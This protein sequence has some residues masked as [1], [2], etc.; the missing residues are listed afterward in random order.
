MS[1]FKHAKNYPIAANELFDLLITKA[2]C[3]RLWPDSF[4]LIDCHRE[5]KLQKGSKTTFCLYFGPF[6]IKYSFYCTN[7]KKDKKIILKQGIGLFKS[8]SLQYLFKQAPSNHTQLVEQ[9]EYTLPSLIGIENLFENTIKRKLKHYIEQRSKKLETDL[10]YKN[11]YPVNTMQIAISGT[12]GLIGAKLKALLEMMGAKIFVL[13]RTACRQENEIFYDYEKGIIE[14]E[15][16]ENLDAV[17]HL[18]GE[19]ITLNPSK[20]KIKLIETSRTKST[21]II[22]Q[23]I[24]QCKNPPKDFL[25]ASACGIYPSYSKDKLTEEASS[26]QD[27]L[28]SICKN[29]E[30]S[31]RVCTKSRVINLRFAPVLFPHKGLLKKITIPAK[32]GLMPI[33]GRGMQ[34][35]SWI[36][37]D[38]A[39]YQI[40]H[41][42]KTKE[43]TGP[44]NIC[45]PNYTTQKEFAKT[46][47]KSLK[48]LQFLRIPEIFLKKITPSFTNKLLLC[49]QK[50]IPKKLLT[51]NAHFAYPRLQDALSH[52]YPD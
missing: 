10:F 29:W 26:G 1:E 4:N 51:T 7:F 45:S 8:F 34:E 39:L 48:R 20:K 44:V 25:V 19:P 40:L 22:A 30:R 52:F 49:D 3:Q 15:K 5:K 16:L 24:N 2:A 42:L 11:K 18:A 13:T 41:I 33:F 38:D 28:C 47:C 32:L 6:K 23:A 31:A 9:I 43:L 27:V 14:A 35:T 21:K 12:S 46:F 36:A 17:I 37:I 50:I